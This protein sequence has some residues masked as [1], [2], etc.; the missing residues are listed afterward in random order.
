MNK[1]ILLLTLMIGSII[2]VET[3]SLKERV[4]KSILHQLDFNLHTT[5]SNILNYILKIEEMSQN[6]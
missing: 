6:A 3:E 2:N 5:I 4:H 1:N